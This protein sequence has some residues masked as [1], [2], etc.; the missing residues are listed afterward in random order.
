MGTRWSYTIPSFIIIQTLR[1]IK[2]LFPHTRISSRERTK[3][4]AASV[5]RPPVPNL[6]D[7]SGSR[8]IYERAMEKGIEKG[9][10]QEK[11]NSERKERE[12]AL[13]MLKD[14]L[15]F[16][17][18]ARYMKLSVEAVADIARENKLI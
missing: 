12:A 14:G 17:Q 18:I 4:M 7:Y 16:E 5:I 10:E 1:Q 2:T 13:E 3:E 8:R 11:R 9:V 6:I 15:S